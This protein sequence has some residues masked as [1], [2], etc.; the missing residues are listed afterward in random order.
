MNEQSEVLMVILRQDKF[1][2]LY[3]FVTKLS[4]KTNKQT[5]KPN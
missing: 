1:M 3:D 5:N 4:E 2:P